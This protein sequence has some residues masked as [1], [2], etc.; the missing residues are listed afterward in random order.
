MSLF[1][2][3]RLSRSDSR[4]IYNGGLELPLALSKYRTSTESVESCSLVAKRTL[5]TIE[6]LF[7]GIS[8]PNPNLFNSSIMP[9][10]E[11]LSIQTV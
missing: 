6:P 4:Q 10:R 1:R 3:S 2:R 11:V 7:I 9:K 5:G 8:S